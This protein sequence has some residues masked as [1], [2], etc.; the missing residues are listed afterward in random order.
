M[1]R[2]YIAEHKSWRNHDPI[3]SGSPRGVWNQ[4]QKATGRD[5]KWLQDFGWR[6]VLDDGVRPQPPL[7]LTEAMILPTEPEPEQKK[8]GWIGIAL[9]LCLLFWAAV[10]Y[11]WIR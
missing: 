8:T 3:T 2:Q 10:Y 7:Q 5:R 6:V 11:F 9:I 1:A 4:L